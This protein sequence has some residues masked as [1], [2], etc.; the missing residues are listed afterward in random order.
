MAKSY[1][2]RDWCIGLLIG[3]QVIAEYERIIH[4]SIEAPNEAMRLKTA[5]N[6][7]STPFMNERP[8]NAPPKRGIMRE[9]IK[10]LW[11][12]D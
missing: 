3:A 9:V 7:G 4:E 12:P 11:L 5:S 6:A 2:C 1:K 10:R 8:E